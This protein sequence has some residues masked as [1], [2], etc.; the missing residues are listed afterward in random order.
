MSSTLPDWLQPLEYFTRPFPSEAIEAAITHRDEAIP[1]LLHALEWA[2]QHAEEATETEPSYMLH[3]YALYLLAQ[4]QETRA[5]PL[6]IR[7]FRHPKYEALTG[8]VVSEDLHRILASTCGGDLEPI[9]TLIEDSSLDEWVRNAA[10]RSLAVHV[11][12]A[13]GSLDVLSAHIG[14]LFAGKLEREPSSTWDALVSVCT[15][16][17]MS[18]HL[19]AIRAAYAEELC[20]SFFDRLEDVEIEI[21]QPLGSSQRVRWTSYELIQDAVTEM[22]D[23][24][25]FQEPT[26]RKR[27]AEGD[28]SAPVEREQPKIGRNDPCPCLSGK[29]YKKCCG[30]GG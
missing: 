27:F 2:E 17:G 19:P 20:D 16:F 15:D 30:S 22:G 25:C 4:F 7:L 21:R 24:H 23:W 26:Y 28:L 9:K 5:F 12:S 13:G 14:T 3:L 8:D 1:H 29:K 18:E 6:I 10:V 11:H